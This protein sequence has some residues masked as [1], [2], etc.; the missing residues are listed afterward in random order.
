MHDTHG[1]GLVLAFT[2]LEGDGRMDFYVGNDGIPADLLH[3]LGNMRFENIAALAGVAVSDNGTAVSS[4]GADWADFDRDGLLDLTVTNWQ[5]DS[6][7]IFRGL[8]NN[9]FLDCSKATDLA[10]GTKNRM[11]F[12]AKWID[13]ENDVRKLANALDA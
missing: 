2:D 11:G 13:F 5:G 6:F 4:M 9:L 3:N 12:G 8:G 7:V 1:I 10:R